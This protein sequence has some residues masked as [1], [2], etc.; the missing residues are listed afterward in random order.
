MLL[1]YLIPVDS[2]PQVEK[3]TS[4][5]KIMVNNDCGIEFG[6]IQKSDPVKNK[7]QFRI[8]VSNEAGYKGYV[9]GYAKII[10]AK[11]AVF[12]SKGCKS[13]IFYFLPGNIIRIKEVECNDNHGANICFEGDYIKYD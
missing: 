6:K 7:F 13:I 9:G 4:K 8:D 11:K 1:L 5:Y 10:S 12:S 3:V 2:F